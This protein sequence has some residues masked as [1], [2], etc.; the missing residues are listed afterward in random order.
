M[1]KAYT[2]IS[3]VS[4]DHSGRSLFVL[5][6][7]V[8]GEQLQGFGADTLVLKV[9]GYLHFCDMKK[10]FVQYLNIFVYL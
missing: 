2:A 3:V 1:I 8:D 5:L 10:I 7:E 9:L 4:P 6:A